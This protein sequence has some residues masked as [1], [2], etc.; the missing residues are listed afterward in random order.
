MYS[1]NSGRWPGSVHPVGLSM[2]A[3]DAFV[4]LVETRPTY[5]AM[6]FGGVPGR[7][8]TTGASMSVAIGLLSP[9]AATLDAATGGT[10]ARAAIRPPVGLAP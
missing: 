10:L 3:T 8:T 6:V 9:D 7:A 2:T 5:S 1:S 4:V